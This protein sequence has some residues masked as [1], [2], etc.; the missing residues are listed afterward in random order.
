[1]RAPGATACAAPSTVKGHWLQS[2]ERQVTSVEQLRGRKGL[3]PWEA[4]D[5]VPRAEDVF[6]ER[7]YCVRWAETIVHPDGRVER[8]R[9]YRAP[10]EGDL[11]RERKVLA[12][13]QERFARWQERGF[14]PSRRIEPGLK[15]TEPIRTR[16]WTHWHHLFTPRQLLLGGLLAEY[17][18]GLGFD[19]MG[20][21]ALLLASG[22]LADQNSRL[23][24]WQGNNDKS[25]QTFYNQALNT[26]LNYSCRPLSMLDGAIMGRRDV[27]P[28]ASL[29]E[30]HVS[31]AR[32]VDWQ[33]DIWI[34]DPG[35]GD[36]IVY[37]EL[38][39]FFLAWYDKRLP[40]LFPGWYSDSKRA[41]AVKGE[42]ETFRLALGECYKRLAEQMSDDGYQVVMFVSQ[43][44]RVW[45]DLAV[46]LWAADL[47]VTAAWTIRTETGAS[48]IRAGNYVQGT[49]ILVLRKRQSQEQ[50]DLVDVH[51]EIQAEV[52][53]QIRA[54]LDVDDKNDPDFG[55]ADYQL[56][57]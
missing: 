50:A 57:A 52:D 34:T 23:C 31:D 5:I 46:V 44:L 4:E 38:S 26:L 54:M 6:Q 51:P 27:Y 43:D 12:L 22:W 17:A 32:S 2:G 33:C 19:E 21:A 39:E 10:S 29:P 9:H 18:E 11:A 14:I 24:R 25:V 28:S 56:A 1:M 49:V 37:D 36:T 3:R 42:G 8:K 7:L 45:A 40:A 48:A 47:H 20:R 30:V 35:Y 53:H 55:D 41:L 16:G 13:L 15:T